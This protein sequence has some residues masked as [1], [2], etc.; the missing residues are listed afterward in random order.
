MRRTA[1]AARHTAGEEEHHTAQAVG[2]TAGEEER[3]IVEEEERRIVEVEVAA[4]SLHRAVAEGEAAGNLLAAD[5]GLAG[6]VGSRRRAVAGEAAGSHLAEEGAGRAAGGTAA[7]DTAGRSLAGV[8]LRRW[9]GGL[10]L[11]GVEILT[12]IRCAAVALV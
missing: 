1:E 8:A 9:L 3:R 7:G 4:G 10:R 2:R 6:A 11:R 12:T 5:I